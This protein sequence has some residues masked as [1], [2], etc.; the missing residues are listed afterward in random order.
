M[1]ARKTVV[2]AVIAALGLSGCA[3]KVSN[4]LGTDCKSTA[5]AEGVAIGTGAGFLLG[6]ITGMN[7][8]GLGLTSA[9]GA[10]LGG[11]LANQ[12]SEAMGCAEKGAMNKATDQAMASK[13]GKQ[14]NWQT[15]NA[16]GTVTATTPYHTTTEGRSCRHVV[17]TTTEKD[18][19]T[20]TEEGDVCKAKSAS[21]SR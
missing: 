8:L 20:S 17:F 7:A 18:G 5:T 12:F 9:S 4:S 6:T 1:I 11:I 10:V 3:Q 13:T 2:S 15:A 14:A 19:G 21:S 16:S